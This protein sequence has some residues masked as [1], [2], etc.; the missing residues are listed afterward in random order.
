MLIVCCHASK[1]CDGDVESKSPVECK[2]PTL[3]SGLLVHLLMGNVRARTGTTGLEMHTV[4]QVHLQAA[5]AC[6]HQ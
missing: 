4:V 1:E 2:S 6:C 3:L 5:P